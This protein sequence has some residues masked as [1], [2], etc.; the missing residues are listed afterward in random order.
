MRTMTQVSRVT[1]KAPPRK[2][3]LTPQY[4]LGQITIVDKILKQQDFLGEI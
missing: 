2:W 1:S 4:G 3:I